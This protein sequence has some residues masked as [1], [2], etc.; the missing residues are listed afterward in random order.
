MPTREE[1]E[2]D[3]REVETLRKALRFKIPDEL[4][5]DAMTLAIC[6]IQR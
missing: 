4:A 3:I 5:L 2:A 1:A 6:E